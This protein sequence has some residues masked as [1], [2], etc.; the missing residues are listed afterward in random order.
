MTFIVLSIFDSSKSTIT[1]VETVVIAYA[2]LQF[3]L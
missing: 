2:I 1:I 3:P